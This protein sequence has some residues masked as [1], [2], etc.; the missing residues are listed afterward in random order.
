MVNY[1][2]NHQNGTHKELFKITSCNVS[3]FEENG[4]YATVKQEP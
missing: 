3:A 4:Y 2:Y 1:D